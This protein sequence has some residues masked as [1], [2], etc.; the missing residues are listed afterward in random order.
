MALVAGMRIL[1]D[2]EMLSL[3]QI[4]TKLILL[5]PNILEGQE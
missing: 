4:T 5:P 2:L 1:E 3:I